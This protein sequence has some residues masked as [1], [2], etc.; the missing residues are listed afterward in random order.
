MQGFH[1]DEWATRRMT[2]LRCSGVG[3]RAGL[4]WKG[5]TQHSEYW[6]CLSLANGI[7]MLWKTIPAI[8]RTILPGFE[9]DFALFF[10]VGTYGLMHLS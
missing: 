3:N 5:T 6:G 1:A 2:G 8:H 10:A 4:L 9:R 7:F